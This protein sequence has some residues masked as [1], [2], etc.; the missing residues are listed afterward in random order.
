MADDII[1][2]LSCSWCGVY[3]EQ[4]H[5]YPVACKSC[6]KEALKDC[7]DNGDSKKI[8]SGVQKATFAELAE[9]IFR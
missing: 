1:D 5:G 6:W 4:G 2:G 9:T 8:M 7:D 3:F